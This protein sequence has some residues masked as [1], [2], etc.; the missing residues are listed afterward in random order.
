MNDNAYRQDPVR[1]SL[2]W[3]YTPDCPSNSEKHRNTL[4]AGPSCV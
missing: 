4:C 3:Y 1:F 2:G